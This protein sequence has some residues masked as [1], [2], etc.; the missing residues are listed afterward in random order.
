MFLRLPGIVHVSCIYFS[1]QQEN[2][3]MPRLQKPFT[4]PRRGDSKTFQLTITPASGLP[5]RVCREWQ[6]KSFQ[7]LPGELSQYR[8]PKTKAAAEAGAFALIRRLEKAL[9]ENYAWKVPDD[10]I[11]A[12][13]WFG[14][15]ETRVKAYTDQASGSDPGG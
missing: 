5:A 2:D 11:T 9:E 13:Q 12:G 4:T 1:A 3:A 15:T 7:D 14:R 10:D 8:N 6:R